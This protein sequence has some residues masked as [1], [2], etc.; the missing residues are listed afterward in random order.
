MYSGEATQIV[1]K[2][3]GIK[4]KGEKIGELNYTK[5][6]QYIYR[7]NS[8]ILHLPPPHDSVL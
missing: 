7:N 5:K 1:L 3:K 2:E 4:R 6:N 8:D